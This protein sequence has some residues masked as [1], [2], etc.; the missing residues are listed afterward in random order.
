VA[1]II[2]KRLGRELQPWDIWYDGFKARSSI[3]EE[4]LNAITQ[5]K[6]P[7]AA[8]L[9]ADLGNMLL[10]LGFTKEKAE[11]L[12]S[13]IAVDPARGSGHAWGASMK[14]EKAH[15]RTRIPATGMNYKGYKDL[16]C[17]KEARKLR[18]YISELVKSFPKDEK[19]LLVAQVVDSSRSITRNMAE[20][21][22]RYT[23]TDTRNF[24]IIAR[25]S[26]TETMEHLTTAFDENYISGEE[27]KT[28]EEKCELVFKL[29]NGYIRYLDESKAAAKPNSKLQNPNSPNS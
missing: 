13:R 25:G 19:F 3:N 11:F 27:L 18:M 9:E 8:A 23:F 10:K 17:Y 6:Y 21:Y 29:T 16:E 5:K 4:S 22:G 2:K 14:S 24:F 20:G 7:N 26:I 28:G 15:L 1:A 12:A